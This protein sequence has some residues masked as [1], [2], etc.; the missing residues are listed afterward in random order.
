MDV[1]ELKKELEATLRKCEALE[2]RIEKSKN[3]VKRCYECYTSYSKKE[4]RDIFV[5]LAEE[6]K[7]IKCELV[8]QIA[9]NANANTR[10]KIYDAIREYILETYED[11]EECFEEFKKLKPYIDEVWFFGE[12]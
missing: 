6:A 11:E 5:K 4:T 9:L 12:K 2:K 8:K 10:D 1:A 7:R 3:N